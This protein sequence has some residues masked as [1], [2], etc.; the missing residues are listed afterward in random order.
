MKIFMKEDI[1]YF[2][3]AIEIFNELEGIE[4]GKLVAYDSVDH[5]SVSYPIY[6]TNKGEHY[7]FLPTYKDSEIEKIFISDI[8]KQSIDGRQ[9]T[10]RI[11]FKEGNRVEVLHSTSLK[12]LN[13]ID[14]VIVSVEETFLFSPHF[15]VEGMKHGVDYVVQSSFD[16]GDLVLFRKEDDRITAVIQG[17]SEDDS[18]EMSFVLGDYLKKIEFLESLF[19]ERLLLDDLS[20]I[21]FELYP[22]AM[23]VE[24][25][26]EIAKHVWIN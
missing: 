10:F 7:C 26:E 25:D 11:T 2:I 5:E 18:I 9:R 24:L 6:T 20:D 16:G 21:I 3:E 17:G 23:Q 4:S 8:E 12:Y 22:L 19:S 15:P 14:G 13:N 1:A